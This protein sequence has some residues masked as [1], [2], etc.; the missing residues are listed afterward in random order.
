MPPESLHVTGPTDFQGQLSTQ[1]T[2]GQ[3]DRSVVTQ[4]WPGIIPQNGTDSYCTSW[5]GP[6]LP[7]KSTPLPGNK[8]ISTV[9]ISA[10]T[11]LSD[12]ALIRDQL[13]LEQLLPADGL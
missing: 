10:N 3:V 13:I 5:A 12:V 4:D 7:L 11:H 9:F 8:S 1:L 2:R 6:V